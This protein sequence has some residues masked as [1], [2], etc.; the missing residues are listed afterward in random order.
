MLFRSAWN[1][2]QMEDGQWYLVDLTYDNKY[3]VE[4]GV[5]YKLFL[6]GIE[7]TNFKYKHDKYHGCW[8]NRKYGG[9]E[10]S[11][12]NISKTSYIKFEVIYPQISEVRRNIFIKF[13]DL[14]KDFKQIN[15]PGNYTI[16]LKD[17]YILTQEDVQNLKDYKSKYKQK[18]IIESDFQKLNKRYALNSQTNEMYFSMDVCLQNIIYEVESTYVEGDNIIVGKKVSNGTRDRKSVV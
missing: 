14:L 8:L 6:A 18:F 15:L 10:Y 12:P 13:S 1:Y 3:I 11:I 17:N 5:V 16:L 9:Q 7:N 4:E 2:V